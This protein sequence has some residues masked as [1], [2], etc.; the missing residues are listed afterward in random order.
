M[1]NCNAQQIEREQVKHNKG[2]EMNEEADYIE[3]A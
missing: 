1:F 2:Y 3:V